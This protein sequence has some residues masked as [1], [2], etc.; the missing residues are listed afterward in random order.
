MYENQAYQKHFMDLNETNTSHYNTCLK[1]PSL[2]PSLKNCLFMNG[3]TR[4]QIDQ[5]IW[6]PEY[7]KEKKRKPSSLICT[8]SNARFIYS[9]MQLLDLYQH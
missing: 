5:S 7:L 3:N 1:F 8:K 2:W 6:S 4:I 9:Y